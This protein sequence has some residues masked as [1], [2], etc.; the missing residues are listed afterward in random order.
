MIKEFAVENF[1]SFKDREE[2]SFEATA[3]KTSE[4]SLVYNIIHPV[5]G[6]VTKILRATVI[7]G[8]N[9]SGKT[10]LLLALV[11][12][13]KLL[14]TPEKDKVSKISSY[15]PFALKEDKT[16]KME[17][18][19]FVNSIE[20]SYKIE[21]DVII[22]KEELK[23]NPNGAKSLIYS[24]TYDEKKCLP[25]INFGANS[26]L[27]KNT[28]NILITNTYNNHTVLSTVNKISIYAPELQNILDWIKKTIN[29]F[30]T[31]DAFSLNDIASIIA[32]MV[33]DNNK[34]ELLLSYLNSADFN[35]NNI[36]YEDKKILIPDEIMSDI[37]SNDTISKEE[38]ERLL[39]NRFAKVT[40]EHKIG[41]ETIVLPLEM[42]SRGT[43][44]SI[45]LANKLYNIIKVNSIYIID[46]IDNSLHNDLFNYF[47]QI[48]FINKH[49]SQ[50]IFST[51]N[52]MLLDEDFIRRDMVWFT[53]KDKTR[54]STIVYSAA[55]FNLHKNVSLRN[56]YKIGKL[57]ATPELSSPFINVSSS[58]ERE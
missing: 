16:T 17:V 5:S 28:R 18:V 53:E 45:N 25:V 33:N 31:N 10:N 22:K 46:E 15:T 2:I 32:D 48:F 39:S 14:F 30:E 21:Y 47:M 20:Y 40:V 35:I 29:D 27:D 51:H 57:G 44:A 3:D 11:N 26:K 38:R 58:E 8:A 6:S 43:L 54:S 36:N 50:L 7:Y 23:F 13:F 9:A 37:I 24:R 1:L 55:D 41:D 49:S 52:Q 19:F 34:K 4:E 42:E 12:I 56:A